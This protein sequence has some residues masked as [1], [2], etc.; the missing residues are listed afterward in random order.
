MLIQQLRPFLSHLIQMHIKE[1]NSEH[2]NENLESKLEMF[3]KE[4]LN[5]VGVPVQLDLYLCF[6]VR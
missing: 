6:S 2:Y 5:D 4:F 3:L 1:K